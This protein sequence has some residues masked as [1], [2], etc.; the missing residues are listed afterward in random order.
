MFHRYISDIYRTVAKGINLKWEAEVP[1]MTRRAP[2]SSSESSKP[3]HTERTGPPAIPQYLLTKQLQW[4]K[5]T[6]KQNKTFQCLFSKSTS[7]PDARPHM[8]VYPLQH[9]HH[10][11]LLPLHSPGCQVW[12]LDIYIWSGSQA[13]WC[14][15]PGWLWQ[16]VRFQDVW[17][18]PSPMDTEGEHCGGC[19]WCTLHLETYKHTVHSFTDK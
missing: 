5:A 12:V 9:S 3:S 2:F 11:W 15:G 7:Y 10:V 13:G 19:T 18:G 17:S 4:D 1:G 14:Q 16:L 6:T 8:E